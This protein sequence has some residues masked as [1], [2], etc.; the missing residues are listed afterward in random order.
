LPG[1]IE[2]YF[3]VTVTQK[4]SHIFELGVIMRPFII[5]LLFTGCIHPNQRVVKID[6]VGWTFDL[7]EGIQFRDSAFDNNGNFRNAKWDTS[8]KQARI[9]LFEIKPKPDNYFNCFIYKRTSSTSDWQ[10]AQVANSRVYFSV[11]RNLS[12]VRI[13]DTGISKQK[14]DGVDFYKEYMKCYISTTKDDIYSYHFSRQYQE[15]DV[16]INIG[17]TDSLLGEQY[18]QI[19]K[20][21]HFKK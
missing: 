3:Y 10:D 17:Y 11:I 14:I 8:F 18:L 5:I 12:S 7:P 16:D 21:S 2:I 1:Q 15:Y 20:K 13:L 4:V 9:L 19:L 6:D